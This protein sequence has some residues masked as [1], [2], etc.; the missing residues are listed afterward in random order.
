VIQIRALCEQSYYLCD[1]DLPILTLC[2]DLVSQLVPSGRQLLAV[3]TPLHKH[4]C[5]HAENKAFSCGENRRLQQ[6][7]H[8]RRAKNLQVGLACAT[9]P[10]PKL[11]R[12]TYWR[13]EF[14][15]DGDVLRNIHFAIAELKDILV[16]R[17]AS[18]KQNG[19]YCAA[20]Q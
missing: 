7:Y 10:N 12:M 3:S 2:F 4:E 13:I 14:H 17:D 20:Q 18:R 8:F 19:G 6:K 5:Q 1:F 11:E 15:E 16:G 9:K